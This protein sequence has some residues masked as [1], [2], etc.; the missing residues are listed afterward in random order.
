M[1]VIKESV[2]AMQDYRVDQEGARIKL[3]QNESPYSIP[4]DLR[5]QMIEHLK[6]A[7]WNRYPLLDPDVLTGAI[8]RYCQFPAQGILVG[9]GSNEMIQSIMLA[10]CNT[11]DKVVV[12]T[13]GFSVYPRVA[14]AIGA[15]VTGIPLDQDFNFDA[16]AL[17]KNAA[18]ARIMIFASPNNPT[19]TAI[20]MSMIEDIL[21]NMTGLLVIDEAYYEFS[22]TTAQ[23]LVKKYPNLAI[24]R[25]MSKA[26]SMAGLRL[27]Y[28][29]GQPDMIR[30]INRVKL[31]FSVD[32]FTQIA[33]Q[34]LMENADKIAR[35][36]DEIIS[37]RERIFLELDI[38]HGL[39]PVPSLTN[40]ILFEV[41]GITGKELYD[42]LYKDGILLRIFTDGRLQHFLRVTI[43]TP[44]ENDVF[45]ERIKLVMEQKRGGK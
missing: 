30:A 6:Q 28:M 38:I 45:L 19:G 22:R 39:R 7:S 2:L 44:R 8:S 41:D 20:D 3:N 10:S 5:A 4:D 31:P 25:T 34:I 23:C 1:N 17:I 33:G 43:G 37:E 13:P 42:E 35:Q 9:N 40:F 15:R 14:A 24:I 32:I 36:V 12:I 27:G 16:P 18:D 21:R 29:L 26:F 11:M